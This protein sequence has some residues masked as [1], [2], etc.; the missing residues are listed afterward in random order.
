M[1]HLT[2]LAA[3]DIASLRE[4]LAWA[5]NNTLADP[6]GGL[7]KDLSELARWFGPATPAMIARGL[8][9]TS[10][11]PAQVAGYADRYPTLMMG[12]GDT[13]ILTLEGAILLDILRT[14]TAG[15]PVDVPT[16]SWADAEA[17]YR[18]WALQKVEAAAAARAGEGSPLS[19]TT[20]G[21]VLT[22]LLL[23]A[24]SRDT[25]LT[26]SPALD[27][28]LDGALLAPANAFAASM[29]KSAR[30]LSEP[31]HTHPIR[32]A[33]ERLGHRL[34]HIERERDGKLLWVAHDPGSWREILD[35]LAREITRH[36]GFD[37]DRATSAFG[38]LVAVHAQR[39]LPACR[40]RRAGSFEPADPVALARAFRGSLEAIP[41]Q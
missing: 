13:V 20:V 10:P 15:Q 26:V 6:A 21:A 5:R 8:E 27:P 22:L 23:G 1:D 18:A 29:S 2:R 31:I 34:V 25:A 19:L 24:R 3:N 16:S 36:K 11:A 28:L 41:P 38:A 4:A 35:P 40:E 14:A 30:P 12:V 17:T 32:Q 39:T 33:R 7:E 9:S 37:L